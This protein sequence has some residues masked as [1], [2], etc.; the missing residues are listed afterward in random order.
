MFFPFRCRHLS[1]KYVDVVLQ[2]NINSSRMTS[3]FIKIKDFIIHQVFPCSLIIQ[4]NWVKNTT[5]FLS[6]WCGNSLLKSWIL[7]PAVTHR[8]CS[9]MHIR[10]SH[11]DTITSAFFLSIEL[12]NHCSYLE[13]S[14]D[15]TA[16]RSQVSAMRVSRIILI[17]TISSNF[18]I[19]V[20]SLCIQ[21]YSAISTFIF[22][23]LYSIIIISLCFF[24]FHNSFCHIVYQHLK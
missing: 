10:N 12:K 7:S 6:D 3:L 8:I 18:F 17:P 24:Y 11:N 5:L 15:Q 13:W 2:Y 14:V 16:S 20:K 19:F 4:Q 1:M 22:W 21:Y 9:L 23:H